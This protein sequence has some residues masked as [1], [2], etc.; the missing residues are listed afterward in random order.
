MAPTYLAPD[1][2]IEEVASGSRPIQAVGTST[3]GFV[4]VAPNAGAFV[5]QAIAVDNWTEFLRRFV[6]E[7]NTSTP[8]SYAVYGFFLNGGRRCYVVNVG[9]NGS[10]SG[11]GTTRTGIDVLEAID[12]VAIVAA[13]GFTDP[14][15]YD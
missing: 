5:N 3:A 13:P 2:Y 7:G 15:S 10:V 8:L 9:T 4:G 11:G 6:A 14:A 1:I 12:E